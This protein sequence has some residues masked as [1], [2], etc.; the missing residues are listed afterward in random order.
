MTDPINTVIIPIVRKD[1]V[2]DAIESLRD[3]TPDNFKI[4]VIAQVEWDA[5][6]FEK[7]FGVVDKLDLL[8]YNYGY[9]QASNFG[10]R[11]TATEFMTVANDDVVFLPGWWEGIMETFEKIPN[12]MVVNPSSPNHPHW[13]NKLP[14]MLLPEAGTVAGVTLLKEAKKGLIIDGIMFWCPT[15]RR[16][17]WEKL[18]FFDEEFTPG[19]GE[20][21]DALARIYQAGYRAVG[22]SLSWV[23]HYWSQS[24]DHLS[25][26]IFLPERRPQW[27]KL[28]TKG[29]GRE[30]LWD[31]DCDQWGKGCVRTRTEVKRMH[32]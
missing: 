3:T 31:P 13:E 1:F 2:F 29:F 17:P 26:G 4:H 20:D 19:S 30:G 6:F 9:A 32:L 23:W 11:H 22:T 5:E 15:F 8:H 10:L 14:D 27:N 25:D 28:S 21:Y 16:E 24:K 12:A 7:L 18:G